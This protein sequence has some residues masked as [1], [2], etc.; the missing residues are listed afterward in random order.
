MTLSQAWWLP[1]FDSQ[2]ALL[3]H[4]PEY[5]MGPLGPVKMH[6]PPRPFQCLVTDMDECLIH[7]FPESFTRD[8]Y[9]RVFNVPAALSI[10]PHIFGVPLTMRDDDSSMLYGIFRPGLIDF[11]NYAFKRF[12]YVVLWSAGM[13][14]YVSQITEYIFSKTDRMPDNVLARTYCD[15]HPESTEDHRLYTKPLKKLRNI[16]PA[17]SL[18]NTLII[19]DN[20]VSSYYNW[21][22]HVL[23]PKW[24]PEPT[25]KACKQALATDRYLYDFIEWCERPEVK[26]ATDVRK[27]DKRNIFSPCIDTGAA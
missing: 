15:E 2:D 12:D 9:N 7:S 24:E 25:V 5:I 26:Y 8:D 3:L 21:A 20:P 19:D 17:I 11:L 22:N 18:A 4:S 27:L 10:R 14:Y 23:I 1:L 6:Q 13:P 16:N